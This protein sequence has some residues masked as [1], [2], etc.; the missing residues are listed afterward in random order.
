MFHPDHE[1]PCTS[2]SSILDGLNGASPHLND[3][4]NFVA[5]C[6]APPQKLAAWAKDRGWNHLRLLS[7]FNNSYNRDYFAENE[8]G[9]QLP[10]L[11]VFQKSPGG[12]TH[13]YNTELLYVPSEKGQDG[14]HVDMI[15][16]IWNVLDY[17]PG[18]RGTNWYPKHY[19]DR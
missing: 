3:T 4:I 16:P 15:W 13:F 19:Y 11:N 17:T 1:R 5:I 2:C 9:D 10:S 8:K 12:M 14:R 18:G 7:S 6:K